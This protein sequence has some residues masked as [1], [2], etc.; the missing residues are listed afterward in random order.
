[1]GLAVALP[2]FQ[3]LHRG[4]AVGNGPFDVGGNPAGEEFHNPGRV[5]FVAEN[6]IF[7]RPDLGMF[8]D[9]PLRSV[10]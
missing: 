6:G 4:L 9:D 1:M 3:R 10:K 8:R 5:L 7:Q 2:A